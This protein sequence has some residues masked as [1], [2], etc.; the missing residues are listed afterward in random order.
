VEF[1]SLSVVDLIALVATLT[2]SGC[3][4]DGGGN[5]ATVSNSIPRIAQTQ[6]RQPGQAAQNSTGSQYSLAPVTKTSTGAPV[7]GDVHVSSDLTNQIVELVTT[8]HVPAE[9][10]PVGDLFLWPGL[11]PRVGGV[12]FLPLNQGVL[13]PV[14]SWGRNCAPVQKPPSYSTW[15]ITGMYVRSPGI[16]CASGTMMTVNP[17]DSLKID[18]SLS[19]TVWT[20]MIL[21]LESG[22]KV[23]F[24]Y[25]LKNQWQNEA[26]FKV[27]SHS[28]AQPVSAV[29][30][31][32]TTISYSSANPG[33][34]K[35]KLQG[36]NDFVSTP[37]L[38]GD[39]ASCSIAQMIL[40]AANIPAGSN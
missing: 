31:T 37:V 29:I 18:M 2:L 24:S 15:W 27:E 39:G 22:E 5:Q 20:Q 11:E 34:C 8:L 1:N 35:I 3:G 38:S 21:D 33:N 32:D 36:V 25:D 9:P 10:Q 19:Q 14:L 7:Y 12:N 16:T 4:R 6:T 17:G 13:Q 28:G 26:I 40:R 30:F 23:S